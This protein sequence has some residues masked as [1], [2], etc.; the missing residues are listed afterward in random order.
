MKAK[1]VLLG[2]LLAVSFSRAG[3]AHYPEFSWDTV[4]VA[5]HFGKDDGIMTREEAE[6]V[7]SR[8]NFI[9]LEKGHG[10]D[11]FGSTEA[12]IE[13]EATQLKRLNPKMKVLFYW[14][15]FLDYSSYDAHREYRRHPEWWL[16]TKSGELD[17]KKGKIMRY[18]LSN[19]EV[20][21][22][23]TGVAANAVVNGHCDGVFMDAFPQV[24]GQANRR[25]WGDEKYAAIQ[26][27]LRDLIQE[28]RRRL[29]DDKLI[30]F[31]GIRSTRHW[32][33]G[34]DFPLADGA[35]IEHFGHFAS[36]SKESML[37]DILEMERAGKAGR[38]VILKAW[39][40]FTFTD[41]R[42]MSKP[43][44]EKRRIARANLL[45]PLACFLAG[46][47]EHCYFI[48]SWGY[49]MKDGC[50]EWY[51][52]FDR[53]LGEPLGGMT[54]EGWELRREYRHASVWVNLESRK[55]RITWKGDAGK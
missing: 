21:A 52:E 2:V 6:F 1:A 25:L 29:G 32:S 55:A 46:A 10:D 50:L 49:R 45:F 54:R 22:W 34:F 9:C 24:T 38:I 28:T 39:P 17:R 48:Y 15:A 36:G 12:G 43:L 11:R 4:P 42:A 53:P 13:A 47:Q 3:E 18:D 40:G 44:E 31:N 37:R 8:S 41:R 19:R 14:N 35:M 23:W 33:M 27:G 26:Q 16:R 20:R 30:V 5:F 51:P 7:A